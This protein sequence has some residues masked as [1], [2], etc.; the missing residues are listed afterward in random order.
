MLYKI[1]NF[2]QFLFRRHLFVSNLTISF[3]LSGLGDLIQQGLEQS[4][5]R[6]NV[7]RTFQMSTAFGLTSGLLCHHWY[8]YLDR[9]FPGRGLRVVLRKVAWDQIVFSPVCIAACLLVSASLEHQDCR[10]ALKQTVQL[11][12]RLY[13]AEW[14]IWPPAQFLNFAFLPTRFRVLY[15]NLI[16]LIFDTYTSYV[17]HEVDLVDDFEEKLVSSGWLPSYKNYANSLN[18]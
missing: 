10:T 6:W 16:S 4:K 14:I 15:D 8:N 11:G 9:V 2:G 18:D 1:T 5:G 12:S 7:R 13:L 3:S 17:K